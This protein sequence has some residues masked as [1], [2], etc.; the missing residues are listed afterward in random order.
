V[1]RGDVEVTLRP[2][3]RAV[4]ASLARRAGTLAST[5]EISED[6]WG[7]RQP[8]TANKSVHNHIARLRRSA[9]DL[10]ETVDGR[11]RIA[12]SARMDATTLTGNGAIPYADLADT[13]AIVG[14]RYRVQERIAADEEDRLA[15]E[16]AAG[17]TP[18]LLER[19][20]RAVANEPFRERRWSLLATA[21]AELG[22]RREALRT[23]H[24]ARS[25]LG[26]VGLEPGPEIGRLEQRILS[27]DEDRPPRQAARIARPIHQH[28]GDPFVG[29]APEL[30][31]LEQMLTAATSAA[32]VH[33]VVIHGA[34]GMGKS[35]L[36]DRFVE[37]QQRL[38]TV[39]RIL[40]GR[41]R[42]MAARPHEMLTDML[43]RLFDQEPH[44]ADPLHEAESAVRAILPHPGTATS[45]PPLL[46]EGMLQAY[47][48]HG[49]S[50][51]IVRISSQPTIWFIDDAQWATDETIEVLERVAESVDGPLLIVVSTRPILD[52]HHAIAGLDRLVPTSTIDLEPFTL[53]E[54]ADLLDLRETDTSIQEVYHQTGGL[55]LY[56]S[57]IARHCRLTRSAVTIES[58]PGTIRDWVRSRIDRLDA[59]I[60]HV[61]RLSAVIGDT[62]DPVLLARSAA[63][64]HLTIDVDR[65]L[66]ELVAIGLLTI[67]RSTGEFH[68]SHSLTRDLVYE[69][70]GV[71]TR[72][73]LHLTVAEQMA[74]GDV[75]DQAF[76]H[77]SLAYHYSLAG[78]SV[79]PL[80]TRHSRRA[81][82]I[83]LAVGAWSAAAEHFRI[84]ADGS[85][86]AD[87]A[88]ALV[89]AGRAHLGAC[90]FHAAAD[91]LR[92]AI[93]I[94][95]VEGD[96]LLQAEATLA[97]VGRAGRGAA[98]DTS[99]AK[100]I[101][102][103]RSALRNIERF[104][105]TGHRL[106]A[107]LR[108]GLERELAF[109]LLL[110]DAVEE[111]QRLLHDSVARVE[112]LD[113]TPI[114][115]LAAAVLGSRYAQ[116]AGHL[117]PERLADIDRVLAMPFDDVGPETLLAAYCYQHEDL[118]RTGD[119]AAAADALDHG[120]A[121]GR[122]YP[123]PYWI[124]SIATWRGLVQLIEGDLEG[125]ERAAFT[126]HTQRTGIDGAAACLGVNLVNIRLYQGRAGEMIDLLRGSVD[127]HPE[128]PAYRAVLALC[129]SEAGDAPLATSQLEWFANARFENLP[130]DTSQLL[131][132][133]VLGHTA[134]DL[135]HREAAELLVPV[136]RPFSG[137]WVILSC[138]G[139]GGA[140]WGPVDHALGRLFTATG[141]DEQAKSHL[142][143][144]RSLAART[145]SPL[146]LQRIDGDLERLGVTAVVS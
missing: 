27:S 17:A 59:E 29:R 122:S 39:T 134:A 9:P 95:H 24:R 26:Q 84:A 4:L 112:R 116:L 108:S 102:M 48:A 109:A 78:P 94:S 115:A 135:Q 30:T 119:L 31:R 91:S 127:Q 142:I 145:R 106:A 46:S 93:E 28:R 140:S 131:A 44:L 50:S 103:I 41:H 43:A 19:L 42:E 92:E 45:T 89:G 133:A 128:I 121:I 100:Q 60:A 90:Q 80:A 82:E 110:S 1:L 22:Q 38:G 54:C 126:A 130:S 77:G 23:L 72:Q 96:P 12:G 105:R 61:L 34:A 139:G 98:L 53:D 57:E 65:A 99:D 16:V 56:A 75:D 143:A 18:D 97:L 51:L 62:V 47:I 141:D 70:T 14:F 137:Q 69:Q 83:E 52:G 79:R 11:Y 118:L 76:D 104:D 101:A 49:V 86:G 73:S 21:Q 117:L 64:S 81:G 33:A 132:A 114:G 40:W 5:Q 138:Y 124:W 13:G 144:A 32:R 63:A 68:F 3:E 6:V 120:A 87:R 123:D 125:A 88:R 20:L 7:E 107:I 10:I 85:T 136:L 111:R 74:R 15:A 55:P 129:A 2:K 35:R 146:V 8:A 67:D 37:E 71:A 113:P 25:E 36:V 58:V 66:D